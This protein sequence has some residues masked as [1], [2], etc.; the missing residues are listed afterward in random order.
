MITI[1]ELAAKKIK[2][3][4]NGEGLP[5]IIR[6]KVVGGG[7]G[8]MSNDLSFEEEKNISDMD[9][10]IPDISGVKIVIDVVSL[11]YLD[12]ISLDYI[13]KDFESG[14]KFIGQ[15]IKSSCGCGK[16]YSA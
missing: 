9:E 16:S 5:L 1:T 3:I 8:G 6:M 14:F 13:D 15:D 7:C 4:A 2:E 10:T 12:G 11:Q